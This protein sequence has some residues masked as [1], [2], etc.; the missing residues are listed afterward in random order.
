MSFKSFIPILI[1]LVIGIGAVVLG[2]LFKIQH[3]PNGSLIVTIGI[4]VQILAVFWLGLKLIIY[5]V[6]KK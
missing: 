5:F 1:L 3:W 6:R 4:F 2:S